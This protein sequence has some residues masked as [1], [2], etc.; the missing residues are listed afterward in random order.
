MLPVTSAVRV[1]NDEVDRWFG[2]HKDVMV[3]GIVDDE[4]IVNPKTLER[5]A[6]IT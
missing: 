1:F 5:I 4:G 2:L 6:R 3:L